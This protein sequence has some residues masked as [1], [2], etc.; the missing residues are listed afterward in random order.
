DRGGDEPVPPGREHAGGNASTYQETRFT[1]A[2]VKRGSH[3]RERRKKVLAQSSGY[4][5][6]KGNA[7]R[8]AKQAVDKSGVNAYRDRRLKK[9]DFRLLRIVR[10][11]SAAGPPR[12]AL[13]LDRAHQ[14][15]GAPPRHVLQPADRGAQEGGLRG[16]PE[17]AGGARGTR[18]ARVWRARRRCQGGAGK[19]PARRWR[20]A[21][22]PS[23]RDLTP[24][25]EATPDAGSTGDAGGALVPGFRTEFEQQASAITDRAAWEALRLH[26]VGRKAGVVRGLLA[27]I[28]EVPAAE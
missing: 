20:G 8:I 21:G 27:R 25:A 11:N 1:M 10:I 14:R 15:R 9:R 5:G 7:Y 19:R 26:W 24:M 16:Q 3:R 22:H 2:R 18:R 4:Y 6:N 12:R 17:D 13:A 23:Q 28:S